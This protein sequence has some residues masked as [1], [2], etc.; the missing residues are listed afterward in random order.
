MKRPTPT[1]S[2]HMGRS[3]HERCHDGNRWRLRRRDQGFTLIE[4]LV[5]GIVVAILAAV[6]VPVFLNQRH[7]AAYAVTKQHSRSIIP[8]I[9]TA[10]ENTQQTLA[11]VTGNVCSNCACRN[12]ANPLKV[13]DPG[14]AATGCGTNWHTMTA[15]LA[16]A[17][18]VSLPSVQALL[19]DGWGY[20]IVFDE[21]E[22]QVGNVCGTSQD[23][24]I[25]GGKDHVQGAGSDDVVTFAPFGGFCTP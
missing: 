3:R 23:T 12:L 1:R 17:S 11:R 19:T 9:V 8:E 16:T 10:R 21:N 4:L 5:V 14:F 13:D 15:R 18:G 2:R 24:I 25:S 20:P 6:A 22:G 7:K